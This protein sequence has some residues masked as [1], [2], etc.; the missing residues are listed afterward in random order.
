MFLVR[1]YPSFIFGFRKEKSVNPLET[2]DKEKAD[3]NV[4]KQNV[5]KIR[6]FW[7]GFRM[8]TPNS[9]IILGTFAMNNQRFTVGS[10]GRQAIPCSITAIV[11]GNILSPEDWN[12][13][14]IDSVLLHGDRIFRISRT[15]NK[16]HPD[17]RMTSDL[18]HPEFFIDEYKCRICATASTVNGNL[19]TEN[20]NCPDLMNGVQNFFKIAKAG[21]ITTQDITA[22][23]WCHKDTQ[24]FYFD[25][26]PSAD[27]G[28]RFCG[29]SACLMRFKCLNALLDF[30]LSI[31][32]KENDSKYYIDKINILDITVISKNDPRLPNQ[33]NTMKEVNL[34][35]S[36]KKS[37][38][39][40]IIQTSKIRRI[41]VSVKISS[42]STSQQMAV[43]HLVNYNN[44]DTDYTYSGLRVNVPL[45]FKQLSSNVSILH[46]WTHEN[47]E[48]YKGKG[49]QN[50][51]NCLF[52]IGM[53]TVNPVKAWLRTTLDEILTLGDAAY[54]QFKIEKP[55]IKELTAIDLNSSKIQIDSQKMIAKVD[56][57][58]ITGT[59]TSRKTSVLNLR[60]A[61][62]EFFLINI[63]G[64]IET[65]IM[66]VAIWIEDEYYCM[67]DPRQCDQNGLRVVED[68]R[69]GG[70]V[71][72]GNEAGN[73]KK[74]NG[75]SCVM[76]FSDINSL[77]V[78]ILK[79]I[80]LGK[81]NVRFVIRNIDIVKDEP[82]TQAWHNFEPGKNIGT[83][84][85]QGS[86]SPDDEELD[87]KSL[88]TVNIAIAIVALVF[89]KKLPPVDWTKETVDDVRR[90]GIEYYNW[91]F[92]PDKDVEQFDFSHLKKVLYVKNQKVNLEL[93][94]AIIVDNINITSMDR[95]LNLEEGINTFFET[96]QFGVV[97][98]KDMSFAIWKD[99]D[100][101]DPTIKTYY[102][103]RTKGKK[104][105]EKT[106]FVDCV[107]R[108]LNVQD[109]AKVIDVNLDYGTEN[110]VQLLIHNVN[111]PQ[112]GNVMTDEEMENEK[113]TTLKPDLYQYISINDETA[114]LNGTINQGNELIFSNQTRDKQ[115]SGNALVALAMTKLHN[116]HLWS[117]EVVDDI[118][119]LGDKITA[120]N[121][122]NLPE[123]EET[124]NWLT[125][126]EITNEFNIG[127]NHIRFELQE[128]S[129]AGKL[130]NLS[131]TLEEFFSEGD[132]GIF[133]MESTIMP[134]WKQDPVFFTMDPKGRDGTAAVLWFTSISAL[135]SYL[136]AT[137]GSVEGDDFSIDSISIENNYET[138][139]TEQEEQ[140]SS[141]EDMW[142]NFERKSEGIWFINGNIEFTD[143]RFAE[144]NRGKQ[145]AAIA[146][147]GI[148]YSNIYLPHRWTAAL[149]DEVIVS[150]DKLH[151]VCVTRL[152]NNTIP[153]VNQIMN[154]ILLSDR[155]INLFIKDCVQSGGLDNRSIKIQDLSSGIEN[156][157][158]Q[159]PAGILIANEDINF[160]VWKFKDFYYCIL[161]KAQIMR[162]TKNQDLVNQLL[163]DIN[164]IDFEI[165]AI[166]V[167]NWNKMSPW[168]F[169]PSPTVH[170]LTLPSLNAYKRLRGEARALLRGSSHQA[171][172]I[173]SEKVRNRQAAANC[174]I[175]LGMSV[176][177]S[178]DTWTKS[179]L[180]EVLSIGNSL[181][182]ESLKASPTKEKLYP[183]EIIRVFHLGHNV[184]TVDVSDPIISGK[185]SLPPPEPETK[186]KKGKKKAK[187]VSKKKKGKVKRG[188]A[189][190]PPLILLEEGIQRFFENNNAGV[191]MIDRKV[192]AIWKQLGVYFLYVSYA[193]NDKDVNDHSGS[194][195]VAWFACM[196][197]FYNFIY[198]NLEGNDK[199][200]TFDI[201]KVLFNITTIQSL[202]CSADLTVC[203]L[204]TVSNISSSKIEKI[205]LSGIKALNNYNYEHKEIGIL[206]GTRNM[207]DTMFD[208]SQR[209]L[210]STA[211]AVVAIVVGS[212]HVP[213]TWTPDIIDAI[214]VYGD[215]LHHDSCRLHKISS[216]NLSPSEL[217][218]VFVVGDFRAYVHVHQYTMTGL[219]Y[220]YDLAETLR[221]FFKSNNCG[222]LHTNN[223]SMAVTQHYGKFYLFYP[224][225]GNGKSNNNE[226]ACVMKFTTVAG[227]AHAFVAN[228]DSDKP[229]VYTLNAVNILNLY[230][231]SNSKRS[232]LLPCGN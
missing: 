104:N 73:E 4:K 162:F 187:P 182:R 20:G 151:S 109:L 84:S 120:E 65:S 1:Y 22:G 24:Y 166:D 79:N 142:Y 223:V 134:I 177:K 174:I 196:Q 90:E 145:S 148:V 193:W 16:V 122:N 107:I 82:G 130:N 71:K 167:I 155:R 214:L 183:D 3:D 188:P 199:F 15:K 38:K 101:K 150:G 131:Q 135:A 195:C 49:A 226:P 190:P 86:N 95:H 197:P 78:H 13:E 221:F 211:I 92:P 76:L 164:V 147:M 14:Y 34:D 212:I 218:K 158:S 97:E 176:I 54:I 201:R 32:N 116:P 204:S 75:K 74:I 139:L 222:I 126:I 143:E 5:K 28:S 72:K 21:V 43:E 18:V 66:A 232:Y 179:T 171:S 106:E 88:G 19:F 194:S 208:E 165:I 8:L 219:L 138:R 69:K 203:E 45:V 123:D 51:V 70:N 27:D 127:V 118:L 153:R 175:A 99:I 68:K 137:I 25:P 117:K 209:G 227:V 7:N 17:V 132:L 103:F 44:F 11:F 161:P 42:S 57:L 26:A 173:F 178:P 9:A 141:T 47:S 33:V 77:A 39:Q 94:E 93:E 168:K 136:A 31:L 89:A 96:Y 163:N 154:E 60:Q 53:K 149:L 200:A 205:T 110:D 225:R 156:F 46:G 144:E 36:D 52:S 160:A 185:V 83:W 113:N 67:F 229:S 55:N 180:D 2:D 61:V 37:E 64:I 228:Y 108:V 192:I 6:K 125:P 35:C 40:S 100:P 105:S 115:Q 170:P 85:L 12:K 216:R 230:F 220:S 217:Q 186:G 215:F 63:S 114:S 129:A 224:C 119:K 23:I 181:Y 210:Q 10:R 202:P 124:R 128:D 111:I 91:C 140:K 152:G 231:F 62:E 184:L 207:N 87:I 213:S 48:M 133:K 80:P 159:Y 29:G 157:F 191:M 102:L 59:L 169:D 146:I 30:I 206:R 112:I 121:M 189:A 56:M 81:K 172:E 50:V 198:S 98:V 58:T 41:P